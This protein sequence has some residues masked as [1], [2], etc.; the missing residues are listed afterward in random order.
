VSDASGKKK[1]K[2]REDRPDDEDDDPGPRPE[3]V[4]E[5]RR[6]NRLQSVNLISY[7]S[8]RGAKVYSALGIAETL[9]ISP[10]G[11]KIAVRES[12]LLGQTLEFDL[13]LG[14][15]IHALKGQLVRGNMRADGRFEFGVHFIDA[16]PLVREAIQHYLSWSGHF[17]GVPKHGAMT[18]GFEGHQLA[19]L[20]QML[21][22]GGKTGVLR[23]MTDYSDAFFGT[24]AFQDG[25]VIWAS[26]SRGMKGAEAAYDL[27]AALRGSF[28]F[29]PD[30][31]AGIA[32][33]MLLAVENI[34]LEALRRRD[35]AV[36]IEKKGST[37]AA[38]K[39]E[40]V[41]PPGSSLPSDSSD[42]LPRIKE[43]EQTQYDENE[44]IDSTPFPPG[45]PIDPTFPP[46]T[47]TD[48]P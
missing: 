5:R 39:V 18:G 32:V 12:L 3:A 11:M 1:K 28:E 43:L 6:S 2:K 15:S 19:D 17:K 45:T 37:T 8:L 16:T 25:K 35:E 46:E 21:G 10:T 14:D 48:A 38:M 20:V 44:T 7:C 30:V 47:S 36:D 22:V 31:P 42:D 13:K 34:L 40:E 41:L 24:M 26:T 9:D 29:R 23:I 33:E 4:R 27:V